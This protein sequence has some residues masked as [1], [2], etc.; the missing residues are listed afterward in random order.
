MKREEKVSRLARLFGEDRNFVARLLEQEDL[1]K[2]PTIEDLLSLLEELRDK[3]TIFKDRFYKIVADR[4]DALSSVE[5][6]SA[7][8]QEEIVKAWSRSRP[9]SKV[10]GDAIRKM[11][12]LLD[13]KEK[14]E[15][16]K[17][18]DPKRHQLKS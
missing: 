9:G 13:D 15:V 5:I 14:V 17:E 3:T 4:H 12:A 6:E 16:T 18:S 7:T 1:E 10:Q 8:T 11:A 2:A